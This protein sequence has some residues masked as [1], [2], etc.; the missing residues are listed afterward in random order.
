M[1]YEN[2]FKMIE[3]WNEIKNKIEKQPAANGVEKII[4]YELTEFL[5]TEG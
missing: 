1:R 5:Q 3:G 4:N 2:L